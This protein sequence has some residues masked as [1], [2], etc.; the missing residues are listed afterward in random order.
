MVRMVE[1]SYLKDTHLGSEEV[2]SRAL[3]QFLTSQV[4]EDDFESSVNLI[5]P[6]RQPI[7]HGIKP[8]S[9]AP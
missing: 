1:L 9:T 4:L 6:L 7:G 8:E 2:S 5:V 3:V